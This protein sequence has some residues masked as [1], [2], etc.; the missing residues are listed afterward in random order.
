MR[1]DIKVVIA[2]E[3]KAADVVVFAVPVGVPGV[4]AVKQPIKD[5][6]TLDILAF[7]GEGGVSILV[8]VLAVLSYS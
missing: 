8:A 3:E 2:G 7:V 6:D 4:L 1:E 5:L